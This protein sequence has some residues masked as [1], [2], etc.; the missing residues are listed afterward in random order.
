[1]AIGV[2]IEMKESSSSVEGLTGGAKTCG[3]QIT[4]IVDDTHRLMTLITGHANRLVL[5][6]VLLD[7][8]FSILIQS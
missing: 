6:N 2:C 7:D 8:S 4:S 1:M 3:S 5:N